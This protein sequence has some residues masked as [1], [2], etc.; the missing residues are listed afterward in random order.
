MIPNVNMM[1]SF[2]LLFFIHGS[3]VIHALQIQSGQHQ[4]QPVSRDSGVSPHQPPLRN[5]RGIQSWQR[6]LGSFFNPCEVCS[7][8]FCPSDKAEEGAVEVQGI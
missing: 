7:L 5:Q 4:H 1:S 2:S 6:T 3:I 8:M